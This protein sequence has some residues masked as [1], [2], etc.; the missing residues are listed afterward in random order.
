EWTYP[1]LIIVD[2]NETHLGQAES[3][4]RARRITIPIVAVTKDENH[5]VSRLIGHS[6]IIEKNRKEIIALNTEAHRFAIKYH[7]SKRAATIRNLK[8]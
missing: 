2:G 8:L 6:I 4:L 1:D 7:R 5:K 3:V